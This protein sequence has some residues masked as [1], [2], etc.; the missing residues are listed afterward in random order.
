L[1]ATD[2]LPVSAGEEFHY[3]DKALG[4]WSALGGGAPWASCPSG[5][6]PGSTADLIHQW[7]RGAVN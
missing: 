1:V 7:W 3:Y 2:V 5:T 4:I 6:L